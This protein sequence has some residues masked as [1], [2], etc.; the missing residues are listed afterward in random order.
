MIYDLN[1]PYDVKTAKEAFL[2][3]INSKCT[4]ELKKKLPIRSDAQNRYLAVLLRYLA[5]QLGYSEEEVK[6][7]IYKRLVNRDIFELE[8]VNKQGN[9]VKYLR[10]SRDLATDEMAL[11]ITRLRNYSSSE[12]GI[13]LPPPTDSAYLSYLEKEVEKYKEFV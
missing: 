1:N 11:S 3:M 5:C 4:I 13:Y 2:D 7:D 8:K 10:S 9:T 12:I 6:V